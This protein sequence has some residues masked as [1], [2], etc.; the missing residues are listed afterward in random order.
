M[1]IALYFKRCVL[2]DIKTNSN[3]IMTSKTCIL[4]LS[5]KNTAR[6]LKGFIRSGN[7]VET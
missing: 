1:R 5:R 2:L 3:T 4:F 7:K 6:T